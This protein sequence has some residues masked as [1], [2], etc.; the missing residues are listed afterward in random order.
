MNKLLALITCF[1]VLFPGAKGHADQK[2]NNVKCSNGFCFTAY[3]PEENSVVVID[4][5]RYYGLPVIFSSEQ[6]FTYFC[7]AIVGKMEAVNIVE[8]RVALGGQRPIGDG[9]HMID[10]D[11]PNSKFFTLSSTGEITESS[12]NVG[13]MIS[14]PLSFSCR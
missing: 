6:A 10:M 9:R 11:T 1:I 2:S 8:S 13:Q 14:V 5:V 3:F 4:E 7:R 12:T